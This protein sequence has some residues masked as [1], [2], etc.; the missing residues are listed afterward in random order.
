MKCYLMSTI[1]FC[2]L[3]LS[4][5]TSD[6]VIGLKGFATRQSDEYYQNSGVVQYFLSELPTWANS[7]S[8]GA[9]HRNFSVRYFNM[10]SLRESYRYE[11]SD[12]LQF[13]YIYNLLSA[14]K[15]KSA[16][17]DKLRPQDEEIIFFEA[18]NRIQSNFFPFRVPKFQT[19]SLIWV[20]PILAQKGEIKKLLSRAD[21]MKGHPVLI[22]NC[23]GA[24]ELRS[25]LS[26]QGIA[27]ENIRLIPTEM[28]SPY[29]ID[30]ELSTSIS[31]DVSDL[32]TKQQDIYFY[33]PKG[34]R[35][36]SING[37]FKQRYY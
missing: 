32:F 34:K 10:K 29:D 25:W 21:I 24:I 19:V 1:F 15:S 2:L 16:G 28:F 36:E 13:Q 35:P 37:K 4:A 27:D 14:A 22:S 3:L 17:V 12:S 5:C 8:E 18:S 23:L 26:S 9:C 31:I 20:D 30:G 6:Q 33:I 7:Y 11:Y